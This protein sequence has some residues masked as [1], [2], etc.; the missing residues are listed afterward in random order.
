MNLNIVDII[1]ILIIG[2]GA[3]IGFKE[4]AIKRATSVI[5]LVLVIILSFTLKN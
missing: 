3:I 5:G 1:I 2:L 4:G